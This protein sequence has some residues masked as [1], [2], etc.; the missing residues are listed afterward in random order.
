MLAVGLMGVIAFYFLGTP[1]PLLLGVLMAVTNIVPI[2]GP[3]IGGAVAV[4]V[5]LFNDPGQAL[6]VAL[7]VLVIQEIESNIVRPVVM[8]SS[9]QLHP[10]VTLLALLLFGSMFG[11]LGA[12]LA[13]PLT[14]A[15]ATIVQVLWVEET[16]DAG[17][18]EIEPVV[19]HRQESAPAPC[20][21]A[22]E[23]V[24]H[25]VRLVLARVQ[26]DV[27]DQRLHVH[28]GRRN[29]SYSAGSVMSRC[30]VPSPS[31]MRR[32]NAARSATAASAVPS[33]PSTLRCRRVER[34]SMP[35]VP[36]PCRMS[37]PSESTRATAPCSCWY[38]AGSRISRPNVPSARLISARVRRSSPS[39]PFRFDVQLVVV[40]QPAQRALAP[41][42]PAR[43]L[44]QVRHDA[45]R[46]SRAP[47]A[48]VM[49]SSMSSDRPATI[50]SPGCSTR[51]PGEPGAMSTNLSPSRP[52][53]RRNARESA[54]SGPAP[55]A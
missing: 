28:D 9:A 23:D 8:S 55:P 53:V 46:L 14:L 29:S 3:W 43:Q 37:A 30:S 50:V 35:S 52:C 12:I 48:C 34:S 44:L 36:S 11:L 4:G 54:G 20:A 45:G 42:Q 13:L 15:I 41:D 32:T 38:R 26:P 17:D 16:L 27:V 25:D 49:N 33:V 6:W 51:A 47:A 39:P 22:S 2:V 19:G 24:D 31:V 1:Y 40:Q 18:D 10:F 7:A 5:T 21:S